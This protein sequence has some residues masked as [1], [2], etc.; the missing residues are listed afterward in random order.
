MTCQSQ[1]FTAS[2]SQERKKNDGAWSN[3]L[4]TKERTSACTVTWLISNREI[5]T[6]WPIASFSL[7]SLSINGLFH[8]TWHISWC[9]VGVD[10]WSGLLKVQSLWA[11]AKSGWG[12][13]AK[14]QNVTLQRP[15]NNLKMVSRV[16]NHMYVIL[17]IYPLDIQDALT[18]YAKIHRTA[19]LSARM[20]LL[21]SSLLMFSNFAQYMTR[22][23]LIRVQS[24]WPFWITHRLCQRQREKLW[25][26]VSHT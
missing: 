9:W 10:W 22:T 18:R 26:S 7:G 24:I 23:A 15:G 25:M 5:L 16:L 14:R 4:I 17:V 12:L 3:S 6:C 13:V 20:E 21:A 11:L 19:T 2:V 8:C 1:V